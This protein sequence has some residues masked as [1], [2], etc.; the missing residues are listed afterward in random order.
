MTARKFVLRTYAHRKAESEKQRARYLR[1]LAPAP[2]CR[3]CYGLAHR[4]CSK[5]KKDQPP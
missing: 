5:C 1:K 3:E 2:L 4:P